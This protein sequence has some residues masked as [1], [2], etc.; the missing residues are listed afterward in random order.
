MGRLMRRHERRVLFALAVTTA[1]ILLASS[2]SAAD[3]TPCAGLGKDATAAS[4]AH[5]WFERFRDGAQDCGVDAKQCAE[6]TALWCADAA[7]DDARVANA[8]FLAPVRLG[9][10]DDAVKIAEYVT[11]PTDEASKCRNALGG[12]GEV[13]VVTVPAGGEVL[14]DGKTYGAAPV[15]LRLASPWWKREVSVTFGDAKIAVSDE[16]LRNVLDPRACE[17]GDLVVQGPEPVAV[18]A[19]AQPLTPDPTPEAKSPAKT[20]DAKTGAKDESWTTPVG[21]W[22]LASIGV[23]TVLAGAGVAIAGEVQAHQ[24]ADTQPGT[25]WAEVEADFQHVDVLRAVG[26]IMMLGGGLVTVFGI[27][28]LAAGARRGSAPST[29]SSW[30][31]STH[32]TGMKLTGRF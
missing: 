8:C 13:R 9:R 28:W 6:Q 30:T 2:L 22:V 15:T 25:P 10:F 1:V 4:Q 23:A 29:A 32:G 5:C 26:G 24:L 3:R 18:A 19:P 21:G 27:V 17:M 14:V 11:E 7:L 16:Q 12:V 20:H 31:L